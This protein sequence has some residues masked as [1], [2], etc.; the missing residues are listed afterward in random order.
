MVD[1]IR[2]DLTER[3]ARELSEV[4][5]EYDPDSDLWGSDGDDDYADSRNGLHP[6]ELR[7]V[8][9]IIDGE[10]VG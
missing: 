4:I 2:G 5:S 7:R 6:V 8:W 9:Q 1:A 3:V 10:L